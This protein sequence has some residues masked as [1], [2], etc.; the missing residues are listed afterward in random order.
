MYEPTGEE[1]ERV[2]REQMRQH[3][4]QAIRCCTEEHTP[5]Q[6]KRVAWGIEHV[7]LMFVG[8]ALRYGDTAHIGSVYSTLL[9]L[10][11]YCPV[12]PIFRKTFRRCMDDWLLSKQ[13]FESAPSA[14]PPLLT[15][16]YIERAH[17]QRSNGC[18]QSY[19]LGTSKTAY[20][21]ALHTAP[22]AMLAPP[23]VKLCQRPVP[24]ADRAEFIQW[25][26]AQLRPAFPSEVWLSTVEASHHGRCGGNATV[27]SDSG[28]RD[29][30]LTDAREAMP[31]G[32]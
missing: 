21:Y 12:P 30:T 24:K 13:L 25:L 3:I 27:Y 6:R 1:I 18:L 4:Y 26:R 20:Q 17:L 31:S 23:R 7:L 14:Q 28:Y 22:T 2:Q 10:S 11:G 8:D 9:A 15:A 19:V 29:W 5:D 32:Y 16:A